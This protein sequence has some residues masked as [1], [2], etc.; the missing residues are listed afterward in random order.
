MIS[1]LYLLGIRFL[2]SPKKQAV[3]IIK[4]KKGLVLAPSGPGLARIDK[5]PFYMKSL[6]NADFNLSDSG[7]AIFLM[8]YFGLGRLQRLSGLGFLEFLLND[9]IFKYP[10]TSLWVMPSE[11]CC[12]KSAAWFTSQNIKVPADFYY[13]APMYARIG[14]VEDKNLLEILEKKKPQY[15]FVCVGSGPQEKLGFWLKRK[16]SYKPAIICIGAAIGFLNGDQTRIPLWADN[17]CLGWLLRCFNNP[18][19]FVPRYLQAFRLVYLVF[20]YRDRAP[21]L[22]GI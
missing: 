10:E 15:V 9:P 20:R 5:D 14:P 6:Q 1:F 16:L 17:L 3:I 7:L 8:Q 22:K 4:K 19:L 12:L 13:V 21:S 11:E 2:N 18:L